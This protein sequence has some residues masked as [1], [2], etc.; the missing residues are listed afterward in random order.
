MG[1]REGLTVQENQKNEIYIEEYDCQGEVM[2]FE[3]CEL[4]A[5]KL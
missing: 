5:M 2:F 1:H 4:E 3:V